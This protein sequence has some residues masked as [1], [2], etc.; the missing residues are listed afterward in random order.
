MEE[1]TPFE[2]QPISIS[3]NVM[4]SFALRTEQLHNEALAVA[5][6]ENEQDC[7]IAVA[8]KASAKKFVDEVEESEMGVA[9]K[10]FDKAHDGICKFMARFQ[11]PVKEDVNMVDR[12]IS[13][14][15]LAEERRRA[16]ENRKR[17][18]EERKKEEDRKIAAAMHLEKSSPKLA[19]AILNT[20]TH[21][22][23][24]TV[25]PL[26]FEDAS[27]GKV[28]DAVVVDKVAFLKMAAMRPEYLGAITINEKELGRMATK[29]EGK[30]VMEGVDLSPRIKTSNRRVA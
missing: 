26:K 14:F 6:I 22:A 13:N 30:I 3:Q 5:V 25:E 18:E 4:Q 21:V 16:E 29:A 12:S 1:L 10:V 23:P 8:W 20:P 2:F 27:V 17:Q 15:Y 24:L 11:K 9:K 19:E 28:W 7:K